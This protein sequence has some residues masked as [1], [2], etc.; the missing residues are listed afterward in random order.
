MIENSWCLGVDIWRAQARPTLGAGGGRKPDPRLEPV[1][2]GGFEYQA[3]LPSCPLPNFEIKTEV[4][5]DFLR[6][7][8]GE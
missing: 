6:D 3:H 5:H 2:C 7:S 4:L 8:Q 1:L